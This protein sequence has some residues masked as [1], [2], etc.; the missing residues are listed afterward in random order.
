M[1]SGFFFALIR[2]EIIIDR[3]DW[4][5]KQGLFEKKSSLTVET[6][7]IIDKKC[8]KNFKEFKSK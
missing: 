2:L 8:W 1:W 6:K 4:K 3:I 5:K 7:P